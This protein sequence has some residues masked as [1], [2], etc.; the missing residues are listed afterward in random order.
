MKYLMLFLTLFLFNACSC[1]AEKGPWNGAQR[2]EAMEVDHQNQQQEQ[3][4]N[5]APGPTF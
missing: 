5:Q 2:Q 3:F 4:R 1:T